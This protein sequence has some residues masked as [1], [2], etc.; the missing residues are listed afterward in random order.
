MQIKFFETKRID[1]ITVY[2]ISIG[3]ILNQISQVLWFFFSSKI[4]W[5]TL[6]YE[7][8]SIYT[9]HTLFFFFDKNT[10]CYQT[11]KPHCVK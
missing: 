8:E 11:V 5:I 1:E 7:R 10:E 9:V 6:H 2:F 4:Y 3:I